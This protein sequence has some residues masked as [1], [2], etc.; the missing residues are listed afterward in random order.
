MIR[1]PTRMILLFVGPALLIYG[2][3][4]LLPALAAFALSLGKFDG[5]SPPIWVGLD[6]YRELFSL[7]SPFF[8][9]LLHNLFLIFVK[10]QNY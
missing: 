10:K 4:S 2:L 5:I 8:Q 3:L 1:L 7:Q 9:S 6:N